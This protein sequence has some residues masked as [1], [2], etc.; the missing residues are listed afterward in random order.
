[1]CFTVHSGCVAVWDPIHV[2][3][4]LCCVRVV[5]WRE[6]RGRERAI[7]TQSKARKSAS[8]RE[9]RLS[10]NGK[11]EDAHTKEDSPSSFL[12]LGSSSNQTQQ[13][14]NKK[15]ER[16]AHRLVVDKKEGEQSHGKRGKGEKMR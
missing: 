13:T 6:G 10:Q 8:K 3:V 7:Q 9:R 4:V 2:V 1:M 12:L 16:D 14:H 15:K 5:C 11:R